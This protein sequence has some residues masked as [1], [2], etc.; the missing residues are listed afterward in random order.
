VPIIQLARKVGAKIGFNT[1]LVK[2]EAFLEE[3]GMEEYKIDVING[4]VVV[5]GI[6]RKPIVSRRR[7]LDLEDSDAPVVTSGRKSLFQTLKDRV[8]AQDDR[9]K[10]LEERVAL[11]EALVFSN[12]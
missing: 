2:V 6:R 10:S 7:M 8:I 3:Y 11:L 4:K 1:P 12:V 9:I 5:K